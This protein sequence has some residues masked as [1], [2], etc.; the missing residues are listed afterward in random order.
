[1]ASFLNKA[2]RFGLYA[3]VSLA[4][5]PSALLTAGGIAGEFE[6]SQNHVAKLLQQL[7]RAGLVHSV[8]GVGGGYQLAR[9]PSTITMLE[10]V[11]ALDGPLSNPCTGCSLQS[12]VPCGQHDVACA[13]HDVLGEL[14]Q[15]AYFTLKSIT[16][17]T[18][19]RRAARPRLAYEEHPR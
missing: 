19:A 9:D 12:P 11:E 2:S 5:D 8:R 16:L 4:R 18:L 15:T 10:V 17:A 6:I 7:T 1:V 13:V 3:L 14:N